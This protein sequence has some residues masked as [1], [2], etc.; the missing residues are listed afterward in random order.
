MGFYFSQEVVIKV[1]NLQELFIYEMDEYF[2]QAFQKWL[3]DNML[4]GMRF[5]DD[6]FIY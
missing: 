3:N 2:L 6:R 1:E 5:A 4:Y